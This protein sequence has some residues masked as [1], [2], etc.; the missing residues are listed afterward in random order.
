MIIE[1]EDLTRKFRRHEAVEGVNLS[2]PEGATCALVGANGAGKTTTMRMLV[3]ILAPDR[4]HAR[5]LGIDSRQLKPEDRL[6]IGY[7]TENQ[8]LPE[9]LSIAQYFEYLRSLYPNWDSALEKKLRGQFELPAGRLLGK[10]SHGMRMK[11]MLIGVLSFR[12]KL[13]I[14]DEPLSGLDPLVRDEVMSGILEQAGETTILISSHELTEIEGCT[15][16]V[17]FMV[18]GRLLFNE[19]IEALSSRFR[20]VSITLGQAPLMKTLPKNWLNLQVDGNLVRFVDSAFEE[21][22][23]LQELARKHFGPLQHFEATPLSLREISKALMRAT[24]EEN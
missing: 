24:R 15:S 13:L 12:P 10:L 1:T 21:E 16:H 18:R 22:S 20:E 9:R 6:R 3:D 23:G 8:T 5:V 7:L 2:V 17:A 19:P 4:G 14:L 11:A